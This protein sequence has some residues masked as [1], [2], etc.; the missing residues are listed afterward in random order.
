MKINFSTLCNTLYV[1]PSTLVI[2]LSVISYCLFS[3]KDEHLV[4]LPLSFISFTPDVAPVGS[5]VTITGTSFS[6]SVNT[7]AVKFNGVNAIVTSS[8]STQLVVTVPALS[9]D[10]KISVTV[11]NVT[12]T[13]ST[14]FIVADRWAKMA[15][16]GG[17]RDGGFYFAAN[18][19]GYL[20]GGGLGGSG[21]KDFWEY[22]PTTNVWTQKQDFKGD[23]R[24]YATAFAI[25]SKGYVTTGFSSGVN[26]V[27]QEVWEYD[28]SNND[29]TKKN[30]FTAGAD[31]HHA[32]GFTIGS[33]GYV[34]TGGIVSSLTVLNDL[35]EYDPA[36]DNW[37]R[38]ADLPGAARINAFGFAIGSKGY[39]GGGLDRS[40]GSN[41]YD[42]FEFDPSI[43]QWTSKAAFPNTSADLLQNSFSSVTTGYIVERTERVLWQ[44][45]PVANNWNKKALLPNDLVSTISFSIGNYGYVGES[46]D[47]IF[48]RYSPE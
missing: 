20:G 26:T 38:K 31:R 3:C 2:I 16:I 4:P 17:K 10:G 19:K 42:I 1:K 40:T 6:T 8:T 37:V 33:K 32:V 11:N 30:D 35:W 14:D 7:N 44:F 48:Y 34:G 9:T 45:N 18:G 13:S 12:V 24:V 15:S 46:F 29:W 27:G 21:G 25:G 23:N 43:N 41:Q 22:D 36:N 5:S 47:D 28:V 39:I